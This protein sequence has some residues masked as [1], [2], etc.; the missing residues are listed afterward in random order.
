[1][2]GS[3]CVVSLDAARA[4]AAAKSAWT[5]VA[6]KS[7]SL[8][9]HSALSFPSA[10]CSAPSTE[11]QEA[12]RG[13]PR[14]PAPNSAAQR[15]PPACAD[16][17][18]RTSFATPTPIDLMQIYGL[19]DEVTRELRT[20]EDGLMQTQVINGEEYPP[21]LYD[22][23]RKRFE[24]V[25]VV[26]AE[27][28]TPEQRRQLFAFGSDTGNLQ[29]GFVMM[30]VLFL[31]EH[32]RIAR[33]LKAEYPGWDD[34]RLF[35]TARNT[36][37]VI[38]IRIV[39]EEYINHISP[40]YLKLLA[41]P[42]GFRNPRWYRQNWMAIE[43]NLLYRWHSL[44]PSSYRIG[45]TDVAI[46]DTLFNTDSVVE[47]GLGTCFEDA[48]NQRAGRVGLF[49]SPP[50]VWEAELASV[51]QGR[52]VGLRAYNDS[53]P[54][55]SPKTSGP[56]PSSRRSSAGWW[57]STHSPKRSPTRSSRHASST[58]RRSR[59]PAGT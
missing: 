58:R 48:S 3:D 40:Y 50:E 41:D 33:S 36:L 29:I 4:D 47:H 20:C 34:E 30:G 12:D 22:G 1:M 10:R 51:R 38:L 57:R 16:A 43:F 37:T 7:S 24:H 45:K 26:R 14:P 56:T 13:Q 46:N 8:G 9:S 59:H 5:T 39:V 53:T 19:A 27:Q 21:Y 49:N 52:A 35:Q 28:I 23:D 17:S 42:T 32:N 54:A 15:S 11:R 25:T 2:P 55:C 31:R 44:V 18:R 6:G